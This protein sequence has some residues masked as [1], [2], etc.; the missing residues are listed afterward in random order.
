MDVV[1]NS[2]FNF[3]AARV[4]AA[5][6]LPDRTGDPSPSSTSSASTL[7]VG[8][9]VGGVAGGLCR[10]AILGTVFW[11]LLRRRRAFRRTAPVTTRE[12]HLQD[13]HDALYHHTAKAKIDSAPLRYVRASYRSPY[14]ML[15]EWH[16]M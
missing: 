11:L 4:L 6:G 16:I 2:T 1:Q 15:M 3:E 10:V 12:A 5:Q 14:Y 8:Q 7:R 13:G 9:I